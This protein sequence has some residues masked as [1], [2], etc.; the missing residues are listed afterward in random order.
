MS[1]TLFE[2]ISLIQ[3]IDKSNN[4]PVVIEDSIQLNLFDNLLGQ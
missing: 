2:K 1:L 3:L 4:I